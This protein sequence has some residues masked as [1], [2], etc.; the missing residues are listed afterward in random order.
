MSVMFGQ[1]V[2]SL[3]DQVH[4]SAIGNMPWVAWFADN[5][6][7]LLTSPFTGLRTRSYWPELVAGLTIAALVFVLGVPRANRSLR[8]FLKFCFP[9]SMWHHRSTWVDWQIIVLNQFFSRSFNVTWRITGALLAGVLV[10]AM[11]RAFGPSPHLLAWTTTTLV[12]YTV[13]FGLADDLGYYIFHLAS[14]RIPCLW[15]FHKVHHSAETLTVLA[16]VRAHPVEYT[17]LGPCKAV[18]TSIVLAPAIYLGTGQATMV[19]IL[20]MNLMACMYC[21]LGTQL[22]HSHIP[23]SFGRVAEHVLISPVMHQIHHSTAPEHW[24]RNMG[25]NFALWD[26]MFGTLY[27][28]DG[29]KELKFGLGEGVPQPYCNGLVAYTLPFWEALPLRARQAIMLHGGRVLQLLLLRRHAFRTAGAVAPHGEP[30]HALIAA[31][32]GG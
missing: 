22:H 23:L 24:N 28:P 11:T 3:Q 18:T 5:L 27:L 13:L 8:R 4:A 15:A 12:L 30:A 16:N 29:R 9:A 26:W 25:G 21:V 19:D 32:D 17:I 10:T 31:N 1:F 2:Q 6:I 7:D 14:H 20:G